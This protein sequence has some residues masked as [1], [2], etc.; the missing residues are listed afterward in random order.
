MTNNIKWGIALIV[1]GFVLQLNNLGIIERITTYWPMLLVL[2]GIL[3]LFKETD[4]SK[5]E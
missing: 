2:F 5:S 4:T 1:I 3:L